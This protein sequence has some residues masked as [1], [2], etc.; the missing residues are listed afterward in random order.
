MLSPCYKIAEYLAALFLSENLSVSEYKYHRCRYNVTVSTMR[1]IVFN[2]D[3]FS[4][5]QVHYYRLTLDK[6]S[7]QWSPG[8]CEFF[9]KEIEWRVKVWQKLIVYMI[10]FEFS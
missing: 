9:S 5:Y 6:R 8:F 4:E 10:Q 1:Q 7:L 2:E 3:V